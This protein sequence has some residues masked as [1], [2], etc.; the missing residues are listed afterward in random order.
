MLIKIRNQQQPEWVDDLE[1]NLE[2]TRQQL[3]ETEKQISKPEHRVEVIQ[4]TTGGSGIGGFFKLISWTVGLVSLV[5]SG[6]VVANRL[7]LQNEVKKS[8]LNP[9][10]GLN[11]EQFVGQWYEIAKFPGR[12]D[13]KVGIMVH[14][15]RKDENTLVENYIYQENDFSGEIIEKQTELTLVDPDKLSKMQKPIIGPTAMNYWVLEVGG[16]YEYAVIGTPD[17]K[18]LWILSRTPEMDLEKYEAVKYRLGKLGFDIEQLMKVP[19]QVVT[20][21]VEDVKPTI[22]EPI[23]ERGL[24]N[25]N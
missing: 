13:R 6:L 19:Q 5:G 20:S 18:H 9:M 4:E 23:A 8:D 14:Y 11:L 15:H 25:M 7:K 21:P 1:Q 16:N 17:R 3:V 2:D 10:P 24:P 22:I 12:G